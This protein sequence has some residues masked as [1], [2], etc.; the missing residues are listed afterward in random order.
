M[1]LLVKNNKNFIK[2]YFDLEVIC[3]GN[4]LLSFRRY[5]DKWIDR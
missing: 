2:N 1:S 5:N 3:K 4:I